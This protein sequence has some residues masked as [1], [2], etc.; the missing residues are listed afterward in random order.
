MSI[1]AGISNAPKEHAVRKPQQQVNN[2][3]ADQEVVSKQVRRDSGQ[4]WVEVEN[5]GK[6][7]TDFRLGVDTAEI[8]HTTVVITPEAIKAPSQVSEAKK[9]LDNLKN[10]FTGM[11][12][13]TYANC[14]HHNRLISKVAE[15]SVGNIFERLALLGMSPQELS[16][17]KEGV[18]QNLIVQN[19]VALD[20][21]LYDETQVEI[22]G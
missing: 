10:K 11:L 19:R 4:Q 1:S 2:P 16:G 13:Q 7:G 14:F 6:K 21:V 8:S 12:E 20:Q 15:W 9:G 18:R 22:L 17:I 3:A 5:K